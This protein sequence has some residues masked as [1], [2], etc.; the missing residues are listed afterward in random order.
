MNG[1]TPSPQISEPGSLLFG[2][3]MRAWLALVIVFTVCAHSLTETIC[4]ALRGEASMIEEPMYSMAVMTLGF[5]FGQKTQTK[6]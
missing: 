3:S 2:V 4:N 5:Y 6:T 1:D